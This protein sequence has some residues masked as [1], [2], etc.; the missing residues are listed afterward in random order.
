MS[1]ALSVPV[2]LLNGWA[3]P[4][5][6]LE[7]LGDY[8]S[9][10]TEVIIPEVVYH[11]SIETTCEHLQQQLP[12]HYV[13]CGWS[14]GG[15]LAIKM[16]QLF[17]GAVNAVITLSSNVQFVAND[18]WQQAMPSEVFN[19]FQRGFHQEPQKTIK[20]FFGLLIKGDQQSRLQRQLLKS[21]HVTHED[22]LMTG[23]HLLA[24]VSLVSRFQVIQCPVL[25][26]L[27]ENDALVPAHAV[28]AI[29]QQWCA[30]DSRHQCVVVAEAGHMLPYPVERISAHLDS[31]LDEVGL[32]S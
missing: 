23:L 13:L 2:V 7:A 11:E 16:A 30:E 3:A 14:L 20:Q 4:A 5:V 27:G 9:A 1:Q 26:L 12:A 32:L 19:E 18:Q 25:M 8:L 24:S 10:Y 15:M 17:P 28:A 6:C 22:A 21:A 31:F 29:S